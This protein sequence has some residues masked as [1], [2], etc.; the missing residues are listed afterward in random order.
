MGNTTKFAAV[1][2]SGIVRWGNFE[3]LIIK[4]LSVNK[5]CTLLL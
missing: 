1:F 5:I 4:K 3:Y 2:V